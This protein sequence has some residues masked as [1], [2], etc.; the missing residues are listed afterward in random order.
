MS[1][2]ASSNKTSL[3]LAVGQCIRAQRK[4]AGLTQAQ[5]AQTCG[6]SRTAMINIEAGYNTT[7]S[8]LER[9]AAALDCAVGDLLPPAEWPSD[10]RYD[11][12]R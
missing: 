1:R 10:E 11:G 2:A 9:I 3:L 6:I 4:D 8:R 7:L 12:R 5:L